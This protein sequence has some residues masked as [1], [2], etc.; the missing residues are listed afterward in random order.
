MAWWCAVAGILVCIT[1]P[2][3]TYNIST[4]FNFF[5]LTISNITNSS[6]YIFISSYLV[7]PNFKT[8]LKGL[9][10][11][12]SKLNEKLPHN[13]WRLGN[14]QEHFNWLTELGQLARVILLLFYIWSIC[15]TS[16]IM[17]PLHPYFILL[18]SSQ[19]GVLF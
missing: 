17:H 12:K 4:L 7:Q 5:C 1:H 10:S 2:S 19:E 18:S 11:N 13:K 16:S 6:H 3:P 14:F 15:C 8:E 9:F